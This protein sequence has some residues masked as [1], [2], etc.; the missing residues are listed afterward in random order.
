MDWVTCVVMP[1]HSDR[2]VVVLILAQVMMFFVRL[3]GP[4]RRMEMTQFGEA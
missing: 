2:A 3:F 4:I 1:C